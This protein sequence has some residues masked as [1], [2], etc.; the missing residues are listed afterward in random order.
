MNF[1]YTLRQPPDKQWG[2]LQ[3]DKS[4]NGM[5]RLLADKKFDIGK[6]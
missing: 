6:K 2:S 5:V 3:P 4:W 1:T